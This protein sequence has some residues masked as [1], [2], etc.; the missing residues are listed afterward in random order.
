MPIQVAVVRSNVKYFTVK[1]CN[2]ITQP[3]NNTQ[4]VKNLIYYLSAEL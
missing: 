1:L 2:N 4:V 3:T